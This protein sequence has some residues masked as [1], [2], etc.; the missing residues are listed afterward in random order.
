MRQGVLAP[1][2]RIEADHAGR[3]HT[4]TVDADGV[5]TLPSGDRFTSAD[6]AGKT[7][8]GT[9]RCTGMT[10]WHITTADGLRLSLREVRNRAQRQGRLGAARNG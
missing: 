6:E 5:I 10:F 2:I 7:V 8:C 3:H 9:R 1:G 4:A